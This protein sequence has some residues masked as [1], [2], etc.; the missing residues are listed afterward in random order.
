[1]TA[2]RGAEG[3]TPE[4]AKAFNKERP[5]MS[6]Y[7]YYCERCKQTLYVDVEERREVPAEVICTNCDYPH[8]VKLFAASTL[9]PVQG[10][11]PNSGC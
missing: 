3:G 10:C 6:Q 5:F 7:V 11:A 1:V 4:R 8:A 9:K 2:A